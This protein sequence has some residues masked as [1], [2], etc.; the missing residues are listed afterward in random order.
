MR[1]SW[2]FTTD[3]NNNVAEIHFRPWLGYLR[4]EQY[5]LNGDVMWEQRVGGVVLKWKV[6]FASLGYTAH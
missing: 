6:V 1:L 5:G 2:L 4:T 3:R